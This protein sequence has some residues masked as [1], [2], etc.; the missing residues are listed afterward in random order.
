MKKR[1]KL[2]EKELAIG[3]WLY[4]KL[5][6]RYRE[7]LVVAQIKCMYMKK[8]GIPAT[9]FENNCILCDKH[10]SVCSECPLYSCSLKF[11]TL[12]AVV[13]NRICGY[14]YFSMC[15]RPF[16]LDERLDACDKIIEA[17]EKDIPDDYVS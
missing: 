12:W 14:N 7:D 10:K 3:M 6:I 15:E 11:K 8:H 13:V 1:M 2:T 4:I 17:I 5:C 9:L 16:T